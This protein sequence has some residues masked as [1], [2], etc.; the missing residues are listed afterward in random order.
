MRPPK[1]GPMTSR[2]LVDAVAAAGLDDYTVFPRDDFA[3]A[4]NADHVVR[5]R[6]FL[7]ELGFDPLDYLRARRD[8]K[9]ADPDD[10][11]APSTSRRPS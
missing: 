2:E 6:A 4:S 9:L 11:A 3:R 5:L 1:F 8:V 10:F 7:A